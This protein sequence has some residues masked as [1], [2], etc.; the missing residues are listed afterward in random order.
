MKI[1]IKNV[2]YG[3]SSNYGN[4]IEINSKIKG[5]LRKKILDH[6]FRH[7]KGKYSLLDF[8]NDFMAK[9][10][11]FL[12]VFKFALKNPEGLINYFVIMYSYYSKS[13]TI[14]QSAIYPFIYFGLIYSLICSFVFSLFRINFLYLLLGF[15][16]IYSG[17]YFILNIILLIYTHYYVSKNR[18]SV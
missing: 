1:P 9:N 13:W 14:N 2:N 7:T 17:F 18:R 12:E 10:S 11:H 6:E 8:K 16:L 15:L 5:K 4:F 3:I